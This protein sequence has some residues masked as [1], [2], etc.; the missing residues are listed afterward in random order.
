LEEQI[1][2]IRERIENFEKE[3][4]PKSVLMNLNQQTLLRV[5]IAI[6]CSVYVE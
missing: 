1:T 6:F 3:I 2:T 4:C 5:V